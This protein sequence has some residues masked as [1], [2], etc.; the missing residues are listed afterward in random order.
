MQKK[1]QVPPKMPG[2]PSDA[3]KNKRR[4]ATQPEMQPNGTEDRKEISTIE[5]P[6]WLETTP[7]EDVFANCMRED[8]N[9]PQLHTPHD[10]VEPPPSPSPSSV[11]RQIDTSIC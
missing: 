9:L 4:R 10:S 6:L 1:T 8:G 2:P 7:L 5:N 11:S 3:R